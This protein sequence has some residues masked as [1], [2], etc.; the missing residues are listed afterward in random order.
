M[1]ILY[2]T[3]LFVKDKRPVCILFPNTHSCLF[4]FS[5]DIKNR[6]AE[7]ANTLASSIIGQSSGMLNM[8]CSFG[9]NFLLPTFSPLEDPRSVA[10]CLIEAV[11][12]PCSFQYVSHLCL[13]SSTLPRYLQY[14]SRV[15]LSITS[16]LFEYIR[17][18]SALNK[19]SIN[20][21]S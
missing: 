16:H 6:R 11:V 8:L 13:L 3:G 20:L 1:D 21:S 2:Y 19:Q 17:C 5:Q 7:I 10:C 18:F 14:Q 4:T 15:H 9:I 12:C